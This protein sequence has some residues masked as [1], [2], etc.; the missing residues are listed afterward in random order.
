MP[1]FALNGATTGEMLDV[2]TDI[3]VAAAAGYGAVELRDVKIE[4]WVQGA[5]ARTSHSVASGK[6]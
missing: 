2:E 6:A 4:R 1:R 3:R 5:Q